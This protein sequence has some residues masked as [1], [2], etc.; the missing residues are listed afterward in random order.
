MG[1]DRA[2]LASRVNLTVRDIRC[3]LVVFFTGMTNN[4]TN[5]LE[6]K[7][8]AEGP[9]SNNSVDSPGEKRTGVV[10]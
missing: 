3:T 10:Y 5:N 7:G 2:L 9:L 1:R 4:S 8:L 6:A